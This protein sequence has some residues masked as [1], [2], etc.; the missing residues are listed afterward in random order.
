M[1]MDSLMTIQV[2]NG[3]STLLAEINSAFDTK[4]V[5]QDDHVIRF[6]SVDIILFFV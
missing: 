4:V 1:R 5:R 2:R 3:I 6:T